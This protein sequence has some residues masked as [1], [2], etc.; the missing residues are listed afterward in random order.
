MYEESIRFRIQGESIRIALR[1]RHS[2][3]QVSICQGSTLIQF[4]ISFL[5]SLLY[6]LRQLIQH[7]QV[8]Q[9]QS[10][11][12]SCLEFWPSRR[13]AGPDKR[14]V[15]RL[16]LDLPTKSQ[17]DQH[18]TFFTPPHQDNKYCQP[19]F[20]DI[21]EL[22]SNFKTTHAEF[23]CQFRTSPQARLY[24]HIRR[25][26]LHHQRHKW[27]PSLSQTHPLQ[28]QRQKALITPPP[29]PRKVHRRQTPTQQRPQ[30]QKSSPA[31]PSG[32]NSTSI[33]T[34][35]ATFTKS[36]SL[37]LDSAPSSTHP[38]WVFPISLPKKWLC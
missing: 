25:W 16:E 37:K 18:P 6:F 19:P 31:D 5:P 15:T 32:K 3:G 35:C 28:I 36:H 24:I 27:T 26:M 4:S 2:K 11:M 8:L 33:P 30:P 12:A 20:H 17:R 1:N 13:R 9:G 22:R 23:L 14:K 21:N 29:L 34:T 38:T 7:W 10:K